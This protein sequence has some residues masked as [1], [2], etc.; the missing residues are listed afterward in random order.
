M[1]LAFGDAVSGGGDQLEFRDG[2]FANS[3]DFA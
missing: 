2:G 3:L 1:K